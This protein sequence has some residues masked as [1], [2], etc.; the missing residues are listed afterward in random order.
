M[1]TGKH[2][3]SRQNSLRNLF[4]Y[5]LTHTYKPLLVRY[6]SV[7]RY[8]TYRGIRLFIPPEVFHPAF[9]FSS[10]L[11]LN[12]ISRQSL[13]KKTFLELGAGS[14]L[15]SFFAAKNGASVTATDINPVAIEYLEKNRQANNVQV[16]IIHSDLFNN[17]PVQLFDVIA[18]NPPYYKKQPKIYADYA[19]YCGE[20]GEYFENLFKKLAGYMNSRSN[21]LLILCDGCDL[22]MIYDMAKKQQFRLI[23]KQTTR[24]LLE[25]NF[26]LKVEQVA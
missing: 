17:I 20:N 16:S 18:I 4:K 1:E 5:F 13:H 23:C 8:Y 25:K 2:Q 21:V 14:G 6:L 3:I 9:F 7:T 15:I 12:Y 11:L 24:T 22:E 10:R 26:I 19:W